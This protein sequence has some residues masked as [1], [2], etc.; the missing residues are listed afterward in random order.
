M[1]ICRESSPPSL[2]VCVCVCCVRMRACASVSKHPLVH[3]RCAPRW[4]TVPQCMWRGVFAVAVSSFQS[5]PPPPLSLTSN[6]SHSPSPRREGS[7]VTNPPSLCLSLSPSL[8]LS[9]SHSFHS[10]MFNSPSLS[11]LSLSHCSLISH[12]LPISLC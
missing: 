12:C 8:S 11:F 6:C 10:T 7:Y 4:T 2:C 3:F 1:I 9:L 5:P